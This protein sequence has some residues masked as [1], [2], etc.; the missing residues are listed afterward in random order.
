M[1][2]NPFKDVLR[3]HAGPVPAAVEA[4]EE[5][6]V[7][8]APAESPKAA[9]A[10][11]I[12]TPVAE[13]PIPPSASERGRALQVLEQENTDTAKE[14]IAAG[15]VTPS[16][17][18]KIEKQ[19]KRLLQQNEVGRF[20][21]IAVQMG[22]CN[23][24]QVAELQEELRSRTL[25]KDRYVPSPKIYNRKVIEGTNNDL[26]GTRMV[27]AGLITPAQRERVVEKQQ[28]LAGAGAQIRF[29]ELAVQLAFCSE[30]DLEALLDDIKKRESNASW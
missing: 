17:A 25:L 8:A 24:V 11:K 18:D 5:P 20:E 29:G 22:F 30:A 1:S 10:P 2:N 6:V 12:P 13:A 4:A 7:S 16:Q 15:L 21:E 9:P 28:K 27:A 26:M 19:I 3:R 23:R 14:C